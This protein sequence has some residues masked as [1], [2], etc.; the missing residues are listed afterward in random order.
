MWHSGID[1]PEPREHGLGWS[2]PATY[3]EMVDLVMQYLASPGMNKPE[4]GALFTNRFAGKI[5]LP[6][7]EWAQIHERVAEFT[8]Y[9]S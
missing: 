7:P 6:A 2:D 3:S 9:V 8:K 5:K 1:H 4:P